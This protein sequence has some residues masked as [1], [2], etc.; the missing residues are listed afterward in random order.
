MRRQCA[1]RRHGRKRGEQVHNAAL[2]A[3]VAAIDYDGTMPRINRSAERRVELVPVLASTF[4]EL[5]YRRATTAQ[6]AERCG[7]TEVALYRLWP[8]K[9]AMFLAAIEHVYDT[10]ILAWESL[11]TA[12]GAQSPAERLLEHESTHHGEFGLHRLVFAGLS[13]ADDEEIRAALARMYRRYFEFI[14][15]RIEEHRAGGKGP[16]AQAAAWALIGMG[17]MSSIGRELGT[18]SRADQKRLWTEVGPPLLG[19]KRRRA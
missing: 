13:E 10:S 2:V 9:R 19:T 11:L 18:M 14:V 1:E 5:G 15:R 16:D 8:D 6:L 17:T 7:M 4:A 12:S 3:I